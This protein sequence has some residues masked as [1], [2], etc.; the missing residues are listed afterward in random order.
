M[1]ALS[2]KPDLASA[3]YDLAVTCLALKQKDCAQEQYAI[4]KRPNRAY[5][6]DCSIKFIVARL[7]D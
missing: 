6:H 4:L 5:Q 3:R 1:K 2:L 7:C